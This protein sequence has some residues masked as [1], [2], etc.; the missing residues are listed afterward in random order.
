M[1]KIDKPNRRRFFRSLF[2]RARHV[3]EVESTP[4][5][6]VSKEKSK[7]NKGEET[8]ASPSLD[9]NTKECA[10]S[11][12]EES[13]TEKKQGKNGEA[14]SIVS[15]SAIALAGVALTVPRP[16]HAWVDDI[17]NGITEKAGAA[18]LEP[19]KSIFG[20]LMEGFGLSNMFGTQEGAKAQGRSTDAINE[21]TTTVETSKIARATETPPHMCH[22]ITEVKFRKK[23]ELGEQ[24]RA[25][26]AVANYVK[27]ATSWG[28]GQYSKL[29]FNSV[30]EGLSDLTGNISDEKKVE[31][32]LKASPIVTESSD[33]LSPSAKSAAMNSVDA[34]I[35][36]L[37]DRI[38]E[39]NLKAQ[40]S[41]ATK[42]LHKIGQHNRLILARQTFVKDI[43]E[44][45]PE[46]AG[47][48]SRYEAKKLEIARTHGGG[49]EWYDEV[50]GKGDPTPLLKDMLLMTG[51][52]NSLLFET[53]QETK[54][55]NKL[56]ASQLIEAIERNERLA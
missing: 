23:V 17:V 5:S 29:V 18:V 33:T 26:R 54:H 25:S 52:T 37:A 6:I 7:E 30:R 1:S 48:A 45:S 41:A 9:R 15:A 35:A 20:N 8:Q 24:K 32:M 34:M 2:T 40:G 14:S 42:A 31:T 46:F 50:I 19:L 56:A 3:A 21:V 51:S 39:P 22:S 38:G 53:L 49:S 28:S 44:R 13:D 27:Q 16:A 10:A 36:P 4:E 43:E 55:G 47:T 11:N 12:T